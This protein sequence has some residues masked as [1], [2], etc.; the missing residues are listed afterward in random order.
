VKKP[1]SSNVS[2]TE[3]LAALDLYWIP[4]GAGN[5]VVEFSGRTFEAA[6]ARWSGRAPCAL[7]HTALV[8]SVGADR[9]FVEMTPVPSPSR[10]APDRGVV[11]EGAVGTSWAR[12][13]RVFRY[14]IRRWRNGHIPDLDHAVGGPVPISDDENLVLAALDAVPF[15]PTPV[16][17]RDELGAGEMWNSNS[18]VSWVLT[19]AGLPAT[20]RPPL[21]GRAPGW[22]AGVAVANGRRE[23]GSNGR[24]VRSPP[25]G[26]MES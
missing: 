18:V 9:W 10:A 26:L 22:N 16:W 21:G 13:L 24:C 3:R 4:L 25:R 20:A 15:V 11:A 14:E 8:A 2:P 5:P 7:F 19:T 23:E 17:G 12:R 6:A 1:A